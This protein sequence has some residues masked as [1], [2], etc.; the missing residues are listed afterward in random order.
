MSENLTPGQLLFTGPLQRFQLK[1]RVQVHCLDCSRFLGI[2]NDDEV[3]E[4]L[5]CDRC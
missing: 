1:P 2:F 3:P 5:L 4:V